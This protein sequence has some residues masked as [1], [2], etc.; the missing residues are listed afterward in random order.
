VGAIPSAATNMSVK[1]LQKWLIE[2]M[3]ILVKLPPPTIEKIKT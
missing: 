2:R 1:K 3:E